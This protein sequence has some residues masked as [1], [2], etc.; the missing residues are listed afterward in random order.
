[1]KD[2]AQNV[3]SLMFSARKEQQFH[4][5]SQFSGE[6]ILQ[7]ILVDAHTLVRQALQRVVSSFPHMCVAASLNRIHAVFAVTDLM[8]VHAI[9]LGPSISNVDSLQL[10]TQLREKPNHC[11]LIV[12]KQSLYPEVVH[13]LIEH[14]V[15]GL[16]DENASEKDLAQAIVAASQGNVFLSRHGYDTLATPMSRSLGCLT[17]REMQVIG[18]LK[19]GESNFRIAHVLGLKEKTIEKYLT[20]IYDKLNVHS[21]VEAILYLQNL[22]F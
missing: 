9:I 22:H 13:T 5:T 3:G 20:S 17:E 6:Q 18:R 14:G 7:V 8:T 21:R 10:V 12:I 15:H 1:M 4:S 16:L 19:H 11:G 2:M